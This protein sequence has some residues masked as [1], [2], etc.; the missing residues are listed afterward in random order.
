MLLSGARTAELCARPSCPC[1]HVCLLDMMC[2]ISLSLS[3]AIAISI[4]LCHVWSLLFRLIADLLVLLFAA[5]F[6]PPTLSDL[7]VYQSE[8]VPH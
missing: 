7:S 5:G 3:L 2:L 1:H 6:L 4:M 8:H